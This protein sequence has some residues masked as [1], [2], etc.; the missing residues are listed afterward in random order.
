MVQ[1]LK[2]LHENVVN[3]VTMDALDFHA[4]TGMIDGLT[5]VTIT[6]VG[7]EIG[8]TAEVVNVGTEIVHG[9]IVVET[10]EI[11]G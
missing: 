7:T 9:A 2:W 11:Q 5:A 3:V 8:E 4:I 6:G 1:P 10:T